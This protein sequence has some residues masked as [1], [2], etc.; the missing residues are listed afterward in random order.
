MKTEIKVGSIKMQN[1]VMP[2]SGTFGY[3]R[4]YSQFY[5]LNRLGAIVSK[6]ATLNP[7]VGNPHPR[8]CETSSGMINSIGLQNEGIEHFLKEAIPFLEK[9]NVPVI[10][11]VSECSVKDY[12]KAVKKLDVPRVNGFEINVSCPNVE[13]EG[14]AFGTDP[15]ATYDVVQAVRESTEKTLITKLTPNVTNIISIAEKAYEAGTDSLS[16]INTILGMAINPKTGEP[17]IHGGGKYMGG[18]SGPAIKPIGVRCVYQVY[19]SE[20]PV[21]IIGIGGI[22][23]GLDA[24]EYIR[25]GATGIGVGT[26][27]FKNPTTPISVIEGI[28]NFMR[29]EGI[30]DINELRGVITE[31]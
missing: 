28:E 17:K 29:E 21:P 25:A 1:P 19:K 15:Q 12:A 10:V 13:G 22:E 24:I 31:L 9:Y 6:S 4:D 30:E 2:A 3:G 8:I 14:M 16:M 11:N 18:L 7:R 23:T 20:V 26:A 5:D 27:N